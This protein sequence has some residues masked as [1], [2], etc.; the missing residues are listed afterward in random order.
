MD[1]SCGAEG[2]V[3]RVGPAAVFDG[4]DLQL[5]RERSAN[6]GLP[7]EAEDGPAVGPGQVSDALPLPPGHVVG[8]E[9]VECE[10]ARRAQEP[11]R[12][13][14]GLLRR[15]VWNS[16]EALDQVEGSGS[17]ARVCDV[18]DENNSVL[19]TMRSASASGRS[20]VYPN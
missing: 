2:R 16:V 8:G 1:V 12:L 14:E 9:D 17:Q 4:D 18:P 13:P 3:G 20:D 11:G 6:V 19:D 7:E 15:D 5:R 10:E